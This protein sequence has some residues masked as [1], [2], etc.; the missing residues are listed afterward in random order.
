MQTAGKHILYIN[1]I[2][3]HLMLYKFYFIMEGFFCQNQAEG[4]SNALSVH[5]TDLD[6][7]FLGHTGRLKVENHFHVCFLF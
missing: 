7:A 3:V 4:V 1:V 5:S 2:F 6:V